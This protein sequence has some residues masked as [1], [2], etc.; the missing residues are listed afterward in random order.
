MAED[1]TYRLSERQANAILELRLNRLTALG[2]E[3]NARSVRTAAWRD[4]T[5]PFLR[6]VHERPLVPLLREQAG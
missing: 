6:H 3:V 5:D 1:G 2:R 4:G